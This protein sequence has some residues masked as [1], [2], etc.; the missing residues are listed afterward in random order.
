[1]HHLLNCSC[2]SIK[3]PEPVEV[4]YHLYLHIKSG[5]SSFA[6]VITLDGF[7]YKGG[8]TGAGNDTAIS[9][10]VAG[11][12]EYTGA[13]DGEDTDKGTGWAESP[14]TTEFS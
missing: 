5:I 6:F 7:K 2:F 14:L 9:G 10:A 11:E 8:G 13:N 3:F 4:K 1:M 12:D